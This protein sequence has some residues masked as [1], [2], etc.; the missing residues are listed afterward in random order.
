MYGFSQFQKYG[1]FCSIMLGHF[2]KHRALISEECSFKFTDHI[3]EMYNLQ[4]KE[5]F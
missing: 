3:K 1:K 4:I 2:L 5:S